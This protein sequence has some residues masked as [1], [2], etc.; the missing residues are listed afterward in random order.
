VRRV[1]RRAVVVGV[2]VLLM[3]VP[4]V[5]LV[6]NDDPLDQERWAEKIATCL[7][8]EGQARNVD[9]HCLQPLWLAAADSGSLVTFD[10]ALRE[11]QTR[12]PGIGATCHAAGH[13][14]GSQSLRTGRLAA[15]IVA[16]AS[17]SRTC[18]NG[19]LH[20]LL[21]RVGLL[22]PDRGRFDEVREACVLLNA[23]NHATGDVCAD[24]SGHAAWI[25]HREF[26]RAYGECA[27][28]EEPG[29]AVNCLGGVI[30]QMFAA[31]GE[32]VTEPAFPSDAPLTD[33]LSLCA[34][35]TGIERRRD[36]V[37]NCYAFIA[38]KFT[39]E[40]SRVTTEVLRDGQ[41]AD[42]AVES[43][44]DA[45]QAAYA[46]CGEFPP[47]GQAMCRE[48][49]AAAVVWAIPD[50]EVLFQRICSSFPPSSGEVCRSARA[51]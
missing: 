19:F 42:D 24:G 20:G 2:L 16:G 28:Y 50:D 7:P 35:L 45:W 37:A 9:Q 23:E 1:T 12:Y 48:W 14:A 32:A 40:A 36:V 31:A 29:L 38:T 33:L 4:V 6:V 51:F 3:I 10:R 49:I 26:S 43:V 21:E 17:H 5:A 39:D 8:G 47:V 41:P 44:L 27:P 22:G 18:N 34:R 25:A 30:M 13:R 15:Q 11:M 46:S